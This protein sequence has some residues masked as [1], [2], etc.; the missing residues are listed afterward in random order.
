MIEQARF[1]KA[2]ALEALRDDVP[3]NLSRYRNDDCFVELL[4]DPSLTFPVDI[5]LETNA[6]ATLVAG[7]KTSA[8]DAD[9]CAAVYEAIK[10]I[11]L[12]DARDERLWTYLCHTHGLRYSRA[13]W[14]IPDND[15]S[16]IAHIRG[17]FFAKSDRQFERDNAMAR[18]WWMAELCNRVESMD[19]RTSLAVL[20]FR[21]DARAQIIERPTMCQNTQVF[22]RI[23]EALAPHMSDGS[24]LFERA[25]NRQFMQDLNAIGG[26]RLLDVL[27]SEGLEAIIAASA[28]FAIG[29]GHGAR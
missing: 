25:I 7:D 19:L 9:N 24:G 20:L 21:S 18:L 29:L 27:P 26:F 22:A 23:L 16:A 13:R 11:T 2:S 8:S 28:R 3:M 17:H 14:P 12:Y 5:V 1:L 6:F 10:G 15:L 4:Q